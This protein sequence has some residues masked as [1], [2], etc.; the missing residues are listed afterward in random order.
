MQLHKLTKNYF[1]LYYIIWKGFESHN[2]FKDIL[3]NVLD[4]MHFSKVIVFKTISYEN[5]RHNDGLTAPQM[6]K[7]H[8]NNIFLFKM[9]S[10]KNCRSLDSFIWSLRDKI[11]SKH[12]NKNPLVLNFLE[13]KNSQR[14][15]AY[16][17]AD[18]EVTWIQVNWL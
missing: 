11:N 12:W 17:N 5:S 9:L 4:G 15:N 7:Q 13:R 6:N 14:K 16:S 18:I 10:T 1:T 8:Q 2:F 3:Q